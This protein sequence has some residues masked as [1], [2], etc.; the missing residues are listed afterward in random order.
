MY[1]QGAHINDLAL[2]SLELHYRKPDPKRDP[3]R[4]QAELFYG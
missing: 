1:S 3:K 2:H 4:S